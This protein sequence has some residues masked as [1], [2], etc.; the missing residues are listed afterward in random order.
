MF[1][2]YMCLEEYSY[3]MESTINIVCVLQVCLE[4]YCYDIERAIDIVCI[5][6]VF[7]GV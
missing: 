1:V 7:R 2:Y 5:L 6:H 3:D 4:E